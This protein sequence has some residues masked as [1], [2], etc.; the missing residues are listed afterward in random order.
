[1]QCANR[2]D[3]FAPWPFVTEPTHSERVPTRREKECVVER[4]RVGESC[5][6]RCFRSLLCG[7]F[8]SAESVRTILALGIQKRG[9]ITVNKEIKQIILNTCDELKLN[10]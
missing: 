9:N 2:V 8:P 10:G 3:L 5:G 7:E 6:T 4:E 1:V